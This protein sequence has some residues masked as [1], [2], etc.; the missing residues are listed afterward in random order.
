MYLF[1]DLE[2]DLEKVPNDEAKIKLTTFYLNTYT[3][4]LETT[5]PILILV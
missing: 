3:D 4:L 5:N 2:K 1:R